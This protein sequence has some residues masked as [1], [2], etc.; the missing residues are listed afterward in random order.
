[1]TGPMLIA[2]NFTGHPCLHLRAGF[3]E[4]ATRGAAS[5]GSGKPTT[6]EPKAAG[7]TFKVP[8]G[9]SLW[10]GYSKRA[11]SSISAWRSRKSSA[12]PPSARNFRDKCGGLNANVGFEERAKPLSEGGTP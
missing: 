3:L 7:R 12:W 10:G 9:I 2:S 1:M 4:L 5:L 6:G 11:R 8:Q